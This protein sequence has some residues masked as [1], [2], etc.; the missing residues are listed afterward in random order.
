MVGLHGDD[1]KIPILAKG[2]TD[3]GRIWTYVRD[4]RP[5][6]GRGPAALFTPHAIGA[7][8]SYAI[9]GWS[10]DTLRRQHDLRHS[11][12]ML[13]EKLPDDLRSGPETALLDEFRC[14]TTRTLLN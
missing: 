3:T 11:I 5:F 1:T 13:W 7:A 6:G 8:N 12:N 4:D 2:K 14:V 9:M 10:T